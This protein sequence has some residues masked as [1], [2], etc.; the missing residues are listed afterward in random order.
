MRP[1]FEPRGSGPPSPAT[2]HRSVSSDDPT[3]CQLLHRSLCRHRDN[4]SCNV[5]HSHV[6]LA[7]GYRLQPSSLTSL[8]PALRGLTSQAVARRLLVCPSCQ[9]ATFHPAGRHQPEHPPSLFHIVLQGLNF[10]DCRQRTLCPRT[11]PSTPPHRALC[12]PAPRPL[13]PRTAPSA[14]LHRALSVGLYPCKEFRPCQRPPA[15]AARHSSCV[16]RAFRR[17]PLVCYSNY[18]RYTASDDVEP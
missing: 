11:A 2:F 1:D 13:R 17:L 14:P 12:A 6:A 4:A 9:L 3:H 5:L 16:V 18:H 8:T 15:M 10:A 7:L